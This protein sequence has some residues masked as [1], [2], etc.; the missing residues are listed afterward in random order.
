MSWIVG[1]RRI[2]VEGVQSGLDDTASVA[3]EKA[4]LELKEQELVEESCSG[5]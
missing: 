3:R 2:Q 1:V 5:A 4:G